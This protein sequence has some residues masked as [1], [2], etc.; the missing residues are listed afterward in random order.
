MTITPAEETHVTTIYS[1]KLSWIVARYLLEASPL[2]KGFQ[3]KAWGYSDPNLRAEPADMEKLLRRDLPEITGVAWQKYA[4]II[5]SPL[6]ESEVLDRLRLSVGAGA[7]SRSTAIVPTLYTTLTIFPCGFAVVSENCGY[8][9]FRHD[10]PF[11]RMTDEEQLR[12]TFWEKLNQ[13]LP[14]P[15]YDGEEPTPKPLTTLRGTVAEF[16]ETL[17]ALGHALSESCLGKFAVRG[18]R[19]EYLIQS[20]GSKRSY[21]RVS[22]H[23]YPVIGDIGRA[24]EIISRHFHPIGFTLAEKTNHRG[25][26]GHEYSNFKR[27]P[28]PIPFSVDT[29]ETAARVRMGALGRIRR[30]F[31]EN[32]PKEMALVDRLCGESISTTTTPAPHNA[33]DATATVGLA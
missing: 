18:G 16:T 8:Q 10:L 5:T 29:A 22:Q 17:E 1:H 31:A 6:T 25:H 15:F 21:P 3:V 30:W 23:N 26:A 28:I 13:R 24:L 19:V 27:A 14:S 4:V 12:A 9:F 7:A 32:A 11:D 2:T 33:A 20:A